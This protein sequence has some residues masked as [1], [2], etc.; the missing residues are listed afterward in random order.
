MTMK[1]FRIFLLTALAAFAALSCKKDEETEV[2]Y[3]DGS[4]RL[5]D[6]KTKTWRCIY[7]EAQIQE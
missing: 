5:V 1:F 4:I 6:E 2:E 7:C 3:M